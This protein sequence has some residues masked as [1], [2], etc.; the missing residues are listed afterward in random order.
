MG[1]GPQRCSEKKSFL[2]RDSGI[3]C[4]LLL[5]CNPAFLDFSAFCGRWKTERLRALPALPSSVFAG[6]RWLLGLMHSAGIISMRWSLPFSAARRRVWFRLGFLARLCG[7]G[8]A[9]CYALCAGF[10]LSS[11]WAWFAKPAL[12]S[13]VPAM[14]S[15]CISAG[16]LLG[17]LGLPSS[18]VDGW[19]RRW[20]RSSSS[21]FFLFF[22]FS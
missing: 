22:F 14:T 8:F 2:V 11:L 21:S 13:P 12:P 19:R 16:L 10:C 7:G 20:W 18:C 3:R 17:F 15:S 5:K 4:W 9:A 6:L 1:R